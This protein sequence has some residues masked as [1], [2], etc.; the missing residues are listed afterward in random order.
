MMFIRSVAL[1]FQNTFTIC[2]DIFLFLLVFVYVAFDIA[3]FIL[4]LCDTR[5]TELSGGWGGSG[6]L[7]QLHRSVHSFFKKNL[8]QMFTNSNSVSMASCFLPLLPSSPLSVFLYPLLLWIL[9]CKIWNL[10]FPERVTY[11]FSYLS[12]YSQSLSFFRC[13]PFDYL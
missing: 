10:F 3:L 7:F 8:C 4:F 11:L 5:F 12:T 9:T 1:S 2:R 6:Q 13:T